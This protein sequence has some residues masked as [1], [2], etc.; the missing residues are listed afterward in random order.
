MQDPD[1]LTWSLRQ[2]KGRI[3]KVHGRVD[4]R[5]S[6]ALYGSLVTGTQQMLTRVLELCPEKGRHGLER[7]SLESRWVMLV[8]KQLLISSFKILFHL[9]I[10]S[11]QSCLDHLIS[12]VGPT[13]FLYHQSLYL[14]F[15]HI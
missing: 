7:S 6:Q 10:S 13:H 5:L 2:A 3:Q 12:F 15:W 1:L 4:A 9:P 11:S 8:L 14:H